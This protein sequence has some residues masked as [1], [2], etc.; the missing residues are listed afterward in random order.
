MNDEYTAMNDE[1]TA[2]VTIYKPDHTV[3]ERCMKFHAWELDNAEKRQH[4]QDVLQILGEDI[5][6][7][8]FPVWRP[9]QVEILQEQLWRARHGK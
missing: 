6:E 9:S 2:K 3:E 1:Y 5:G 4:L 7:K 8:L